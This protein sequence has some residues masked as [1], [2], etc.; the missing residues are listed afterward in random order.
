MR[1]WF[2]FSVACS[3]KHNAQINPFCC[4]SCRILFFVASYAC[5]EIQLQV[6]LVQFDFFPVTMC[7]A[8]EISSLFPLIYYEMIWPSWIFPLFQWLGNLTLD[9]YEDD[10]EFADPAGSF[11]GLRRFK[12]NCSN[13][14]SLIEKSSMQLMKWEDFEVSL[15]G[16]LIPHLFYHFEVSWFAISDIKS[17]CD[18]RTRELGIGDLA[19]SCHFLGSP[20][21]LVYI[22]FLCIKI[23]NPM[24]SLALFCR[25]FLLLKAS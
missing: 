13:F 22:M 25:Q 15:L 5:F 20:F 14:G 2:S 12:R 7:H 16:G 8:L 4:F 6:L 23:F 21:F 11:K 19:A 1:F 3:H 18:C 9:A 10:C 17:S 24:N